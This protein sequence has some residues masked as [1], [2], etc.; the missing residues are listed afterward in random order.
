[1][2]VHTHFGNKEHLLCDEIIKMH[3]MDFD[4]FPIG[5]RL[6]ER[7]EMG[8]CCQFYHASFFLFPI[9]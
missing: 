1:M 6:I 4:V 9:F 3:E 7:I 8:I 2:F 5:R